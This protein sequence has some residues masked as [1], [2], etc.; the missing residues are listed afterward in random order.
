M[1]LVL[2]RDDELLAPDQARLRGDRAR[3][4]LD[5]LGVEVGQCLKAGRPDG[6]RGVARVLR[7]SEDAVDLALQ[8]DRDPEPAP[9]VDLLLALPRPKVL[10]RIIEH[11]VA[12][13]VGR[14]VLIR[15]WR[16]EKSYFQTDLLRPDRLRALI[17]AG[18]EMAGCTRVP[19]VIVA[20]RFRPFVEDRLDEAF[21]RG[22][23]RWLLDAQATETLLQ[24]ARQP[25]D[26]SC[27]AIGPEGG[28]IE[29]ERNLLLEHGFELASLGERVLRVETAATLGLGVIHLAKKSGAAL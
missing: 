29:F 14:M 11:A 26:R 7:I 23:P 22:N 12:L 17:H 25:A 21:G 1:N 10:G 20:P 28:F 13:G 24:C 3:H 8:L 27:L 5:T 18:L 9:D 15:S 19:E 2:V 16:V 6:P 4:L